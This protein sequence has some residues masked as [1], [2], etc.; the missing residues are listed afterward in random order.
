MII[1]TPFDNDL[2]QI[3]SFAY[4][5]WIGENFAKTKIQIIGD[6]HY[7][8]GDD[9]LPNNKQATR[10]LI[11]NN[12]VNSDNPKFSKAPF[13]RVVEKIISNRQLTLPQERAAFWKNV[14]FLNLS[15]RLMPTIKERPTDAD[16]DL[17][18]ETFLKYALVT[19]PTICIKLGID[20]IGR[21]GYFL[22]NNETD[23]KRN[24]KEF[25]TRPFVLNLTNGDYHL[26]IVVINHP[27]GSRGFDTAKWTSL[28]HKE[29][30]EL[31]KLLSDR[32]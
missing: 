5:P 11:N 16:F 28:I 6:S 23:W 3:S 4:Q 26:K 7:D 31:Q 27:T 8:D 25:Y 24:V 21:L 15:Q 13:L 19:K 14:S 30:P 10:Q 12:G 9:W 18:W 29:F 17:G 1:T 20:G 2:L 32:E 22:N